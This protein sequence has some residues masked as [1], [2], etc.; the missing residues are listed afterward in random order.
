MFTTLRYDR[1][2]KLV[3]Q[4]GSELSSG[5]CINCRS[6]K[7]CHA[8]SHGHF[9]PNRGE[10]VVLMQVYLAKMYGGTRW[11]WPMSLQGYRV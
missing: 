6:R 9:S 10:K 8:G 2:N 5:A 3:E 7:V 4:P 1:Q 11:L